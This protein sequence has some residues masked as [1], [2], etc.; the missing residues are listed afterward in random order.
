ML[1]FLVYLVIRFLLFFMCK[2]DKAALKAVP[3]NGPMILVGNHINF[4]DAPLA[5][6]FLY[7][8]RIV[9]LVKKETF[10]NPVLKFLFTVW[11]SI[12]INRGTADFRAMGKAA[13]IIQDGMFLAIFP[14]GTRTN[15]GCLIKGHPGVAIMAIKSN[16]PLLPIV[17]YGTESF[18]E[19]I[20][21]WRRT[22]IT[23]KIGEPFL[24]KPG[25]SNPG[26]E[27][28]QLM[29]DEIMY[30][31]A[32]LLPESNRGYYAD[33]SK[34]TTHYLQFDRRNNFSTGAFVAPEIQEQDT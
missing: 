21:K 30:Q 28:R 18:H 34:A 7:P 25:R 16:V 4:L 8:R 22:R 5:A 15:D 23:F 12:P 19:N 20:R 11:G 10:D 9:S 17:H 14:E 32:K 13:K 31:L 2:V 1:K 33:L 6:T 29:T 26:R 27:E 24:V 3:Q